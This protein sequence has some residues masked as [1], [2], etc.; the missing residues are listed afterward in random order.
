MSKDISGTNE[1]PD[2]SCDLKYTPVFD[3]LTSAVEYLISENGFF[4]NL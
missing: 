2:G 1:Y 4:K 3:K